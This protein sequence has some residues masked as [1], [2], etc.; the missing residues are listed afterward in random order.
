VGPADSGVAFPARSLSYAP[1]L[2]ALAR[3]EGAPPRP[4]VPLL[5]DGGRQV[6]AA[7]AGGRA[8]A[9]ALPLE[10]LVA[11]VAAGAPLV[12]FGALTRRRG[13][14]LVVARGGGLSGGPEAL[15]GGTW[16]GASVGLQTGGE[17]SERLVRLWWLAAGP[18]AAPPATYLDRDPWAGEP[19]W[20][21]FTTGEALVAALA[22]GRIAAFC[23]PSL[24]AAQATVLGTGQVVGN[25]SDG[26]TGADVGAALPVVL[27]ARRDRVQAG[28]PTVQYLRVACAR[29]AAALTGGEGPFLAAQAL[30]EIDPVA[31][32]RALRLDVPPGAPGLYATDGRLSPA[33]VGRYLDLAAQAGTA[34]AVDPAGLVAA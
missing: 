18:P 33:A 26:S 23:G 6:A 34:L 27:A 31:L 17:G 2:L 32:D 24:A 1:L 20:I 5:S 22:D 11:A 9:G 3:G 25:F 13:A 4:L 28:D 8:A 15:L 7:V 29:A 12:A 30:P 14:Q 21:G 10:D 19:R 16:R